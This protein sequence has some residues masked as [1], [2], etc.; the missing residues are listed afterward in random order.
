ML[1]Q[2]PPDMSQVCARPPLKTISTGTPMRVSLAHRETLRGPMI[3]TGTFLLHYRVVE[4]IGEG[5]MG[6]VWKTT[7]STLDRDVLRRPHEDRVAGG[8]APRGERRSMIVTRGCPPSGYLVVIC[9]G[10]MTTWLARRSTL[11]S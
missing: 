1:A 5:G 7:D 8:P 3:T 6:A 9:R 11:A 2:I 4:K 10:N